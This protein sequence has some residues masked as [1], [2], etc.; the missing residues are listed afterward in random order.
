MGDH[1]WLIKVDEGLLYIS[2]IRIW[3][4]S[5]TLAGSGGI[6]DTFLHIVDTIIVHSVPLTV[7]EFSRST[8]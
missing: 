3:L 1:K 5:F 2:F 8:N 6:R 7:K 4:L